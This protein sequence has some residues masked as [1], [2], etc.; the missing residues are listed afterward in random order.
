VRGRRAKKVLVFGVFDGLH[1]GHRAF[2]R[3]AR[4]LGTL[5]VAV[6]LDSAVRKMKERSPRYALRRRIA[7]VRKEG[8]AEKV[9]PGDLVPSSYA[10]VLRHKPHVIALGYDQKK[11]LKD[12]MR[13]LHRF[14]PRPKLKILRAHKPKRYHS[15]FFGGNRSRG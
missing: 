5:F 10:V 1:E 9:I 3:Q 7:H 14:R 11:L 13:N 6:A 2:L 12:L 15:R 4:R 8:L